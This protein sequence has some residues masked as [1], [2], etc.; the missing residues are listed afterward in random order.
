MGEA[1]VQNPLYLVVFLSIYN[2]WWWW[3]WWLHL[4]TQERI[5][6]SW[7]EFDHIEDWA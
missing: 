2:L 4:S 6:G 1:A 7:E 5:L 3:W